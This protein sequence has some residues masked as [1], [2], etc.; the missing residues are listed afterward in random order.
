MPQFTSTHQFMLAQMANLKDLTN[1]NK[2]LRMAAIESADA[3]QSRIQQKGLKSDG[4]S[5]GKYSSK[6]YKGSFGKAESFGSKK[7][8]K[9]VTGNEGYK[10]LR[11]K[12]GLQT[13][14]IDYTFSGDMWKSWKV[15]PIDNNSLGVAFVSSDQ[16]DIANALDNRFGDA[17]I[18]SEQEFKQAMGTI[19]I[20]ILK[21]LN[22]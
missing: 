16:N 17:F 9:K 21:I 6:T 2:V 4:N 8:L 10:E 5:I 7:R 20:Q 12:L 15:I 18:L 22:K 11:Q 1:V 3:V 19:N 14:Y 13:N